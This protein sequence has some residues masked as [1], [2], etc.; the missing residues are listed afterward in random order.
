VNRWPDVVAL[1]AGSNAPWPF[2]VTNVPAYNIMTITAAFEE[3]DGARGNLAAAPFEV[4]PNAV[5]TVMV[6]NRSN[7]TGTQAGALF[8]TF[9][10]LEAG[11]ICG[12]P[13]NSFA[14]D[15]RHPG[16]RNATPEAPCHA[17]A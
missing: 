12:E 6:S 14:Q 9:E 16:S 1:P 7:S 4:R 3:A 5:T 8:T 2:E 11:N 17:A 10:Q 15:G 13:K